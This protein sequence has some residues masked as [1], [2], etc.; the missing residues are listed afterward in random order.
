MDAEY[1]NIHQRDN[2]SH[3]VTR[4]EEIKIITSYK[5]CISEIVSLI[6]SQ[7]YLI[8]KS[9]FK[10]SDKRVALKFD[11]RKYIR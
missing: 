6:V 7:T 4:Y 1:I 11:E 9:N 3:E 10:I 2:D 5:S 8:V